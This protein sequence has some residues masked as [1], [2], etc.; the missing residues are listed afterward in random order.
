MK[1]WKI[2]F[3]KIE[4]ILKRE[5]GISKEDFYLKYSW[6]QI[7]EYLLNLPPERIVNLDNTKLSKQE[8][9]TKYMEALYD[10]DTQSVATD[11]EK[12]ELRVKKIEL[13]NKLKSNPNDEKRKKELEEVKEKLGA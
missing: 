8:R 10:R 13:Q 11:R 7:Q 1:G 9:Q 12:Y 5:Y 2:N 4:G 6:E 3:D